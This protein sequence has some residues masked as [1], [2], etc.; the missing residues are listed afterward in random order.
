MCAEVGL[1]VVRLRRVRIGPLRLGTL[2][3]G[4]FRDLNRREVE[5]LARG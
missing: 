3:A 1:D 2:A 4:A 5:A